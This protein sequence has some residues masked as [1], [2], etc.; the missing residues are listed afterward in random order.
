MISYITRRILVVVFSH[1][2]VL[3]PGYKEIYL[4]FVEVVYITYM[5]SVCAR[6]V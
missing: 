2:D 5:V 1:M 4:G 6:F 3:Y